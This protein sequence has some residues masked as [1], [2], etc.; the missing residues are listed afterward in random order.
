MKETI[1]F[2][3]TLQAILTRIQTVR[4]QLRQAS[5]TTNALKNQLDGLTEAQEILER[6]NRTRIR[7]PRSGKKPPAKT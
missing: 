6:A 4:G 3:E 7:S 1:P 2:D 5:E